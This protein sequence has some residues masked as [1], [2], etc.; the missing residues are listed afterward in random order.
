VYTEAPKEIHG[1]VIISEEALEKHPVKSQLTVKT[2]RSL[3]PPEKRE[4]WNQIKAHL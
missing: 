4:L 3:S 1:L 2:F